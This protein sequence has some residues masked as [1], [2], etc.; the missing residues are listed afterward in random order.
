MN[1]VAWWDLSE[2][3]G[4][5]ISCCLLKK[6]D[7]KPLMDFESVTKSIQ[8]PECTEFGSYRFHFQVPPVISK[9][10]FYSHY[11]NCV[12]TFFSIF[13]LFRNQTMDEESNKEIL[14][15][16][17]A[18]VVPKNKNELNVKKW[19]WRIWLQFRSN[20][21]PSA[22]I[23]MSIWADWERNGGKT[24]IVYC[25]SQMK[26]VFYLNLIVLEM[27]LCNVNHLLNALFA[28]K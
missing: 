11:Q 26:N 7:Q 6:F 9:S 12:Q 24:A 4:T 25:C 3:F 8:K 22:C 16:K 19:L 17:L 2:D 28:A 20:W 14:N 21:T 1:D 15:Q 27:N 18:P 13:F 10:N 5:G 23:K